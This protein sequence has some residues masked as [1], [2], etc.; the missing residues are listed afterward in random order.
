MTKLL[1]EAPDAVV[2]LDEVEKAHPD[3]L[4]VMLQLFDE[5][6]LT[7]GQGKT[8]DCQDALFV[9]TS[10][11]AADVIAEHSWRLRQQ[12]V[13]EGGEDDQQAHELSKDFKEEVI[14][15]ILKAHFMRDEFLGRID[16]ILCVLAPGTTIGLLAGRPA[17]IRATATPPFGPRWVGSGGC[18]PTLFDSHGAAPRR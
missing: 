8:I 12:A 7:D 13:L 18:V 3:V 2:L 1:K 4:T 16:E 10:N 17:I 14:R 11:L 5:G 9:M 15:P 6:R